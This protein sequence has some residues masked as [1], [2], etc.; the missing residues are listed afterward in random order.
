MEIA[1]IIGAVVLAIVAGLAI[2]KIIKLTIDVIKNL[3][4]KKN[5]KEAVLQMKGVIAQAIKDPDVPHMKFADLDKEAVVCAE[6]DEEGEIVG[7]LQ[8]FKDVDQNVNN[9]L[10][11]TPKG[12]VLIED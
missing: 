2:Y 10:E 1:V 8:V 6:V 4:K 11:N 3:R 9:M 12:V 5:T 7:K